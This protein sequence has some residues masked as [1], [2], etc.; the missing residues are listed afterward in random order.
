MPT[1]GSSDES[2]PASR[3]DL[4]AGADIV[5]DQASKPFFQGFRCGKPDPWFNMTDQGFTTKFKNAQ[6]SAK[7]RFPADRPVRRYVDSLSRSG[8]Q[9]NGPTPVNDVVIHEPR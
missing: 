3:Q 1:A 7:R 8:L 5:S 6:A 4:L 9:G 2:W